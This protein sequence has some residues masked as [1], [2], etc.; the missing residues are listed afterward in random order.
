[1]SIHFV[2]WK[3]NLG[4]TI[5]C[6]LRFLIFFF[7]FFTSVTKHPQY[8]SSQYRLNSGLNLGC[9]S[10]LFSQ[11]VC[12]IHLIFIKC[13]KNRIK[14]P[15]SECIQMCCFVLPTVHMSEI[16]GL[17]KDTYNKNKFWHL[18]LKKLVQ[19]LVNYQIISPYIYISGIIGE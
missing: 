18:C 2:I 15:C 13:Q 16:Q 9:K 8:S 1:M 4:E 6:C 14:S 10:Q 5:N 17:Y 7:F 3:L 19:Q 12:V 11:T